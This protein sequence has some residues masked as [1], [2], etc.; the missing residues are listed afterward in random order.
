MLLSQFVASLDT[1]S[2]LQRTKHSSPSAPLE[3]VSPLLGFLGLNIFLA[4][5]RLVERRFDCSEIFCADFE[6]CISQS[7]QIRTARAVALENELAEPLHR[8]KSIEL[9]DEPKYLAEKS[10]W[11]K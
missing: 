9:N 11:S 2:E 1:T 10:P 7:R 6:K 3:K 4:H 5:P 8:V